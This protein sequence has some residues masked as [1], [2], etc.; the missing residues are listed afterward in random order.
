MGDEDEWSDISRE[1]ENTVD[2]FEREAINQ[3]GSGLWSQIA[4]KD[5]K[6]RTPIGSPRKRKRKTSESGKEANDNLAA[7][8][9]ASLSELNPGTQVAPDGRKLSSAVGSPRK[10]E[11]NASETGRQANGRLATFMLAN[12]LSDANKQRPDSTLSKKINHIVRRHKFFT[13]QSL[14]TYTTLLR[15]AFERDVYDFTRALKLTRSQ[16]KTA[17]VCARRLYGEESYDSDNSRRDDEEV[18]HPAAVLIEGPAL[19]GL[20]PPATP[21]V[22]SIQIEMT[23]QNGVL[24]KEAGRKRAN[25]WKDDHY[26]KK[27]RTN[28]DSNGDDSLKEGQDDTY[29]A[30]DTTQPPERR[31][32]S[33]APKEQPGMYTNTAHSMVHHR[34]PP[35]AEDSH[36]ALSSISE[37][38]AVNG[39]SNEDHQS[40]RF[41]QKAQNQ[42]KI[43]GEDGHYQGPT[44]NAPA[45][46]VDSDPPAASPNNT[47]K[48]AE[49]R[50]MP[51][52]TGQ[53]DVQEHSLTADQISQIIAG[54]KKRVDQL[55]EKLFTEGET[56]S[57]TG[58]EIDMVLKSFN[59][60]SLTAADL[61]HIRGGMKSVKMTRLA[62][63]A[64]LD[65]LSAVDPK[66]TVVDSCP[67]R[68]V[69]ANL[70][71][72]LSKTAED[73]N[74]NEGAEAGE[75]S[76]EYAVEELDQR[77]K[78]NEERKMVGEL[79]TKLLALKETNCVAA[80]I[81]E[82]YAKGTITVITFD[83]ILQALSGDRAETTTIFKLLK[84][85]QVD[86]AG[87]MDNIHSSN[88][89]WMAAR[90]RA[91]V[92]ESKAEETMECNGEAQKQN[93]DLVTERTGE[94]SWAERE[95]DQIE[96]E[97]CFD[98]EKLT[99]R[100]LRHYRKSTLTITKLKYIITDPDTDRADLAVVL[101]DMKQLLG[102]QRYLALKGNSPAIESNCVEAVARLNQ[103][104]NRRLSDAAKKALIEKENRD[105]AVDQLH[106]REKAKENQQKQHQVPVAGF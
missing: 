100:A 77:R 84:G 22:P 16:A 38:I 46:K 56:V 62:V 9:L 12:L 85:W 10:R 45:A 4:P 51:V 89:E 2:D 8:M 11:R 13:E 104:A 93:E 31:R 106:M 82:M 79:L 59:D 61:E 32:E 1:T 29:A 99:N 24:Q 55:L 30:E 39:L 87:V 19:V 91:E 28:D 47:Q 14:S 36:V 41:V 48:V 15:R 43:T 102:G 66:L 40:G 33:E 58:N 17:V 70:G 7:L 54:R 96:H 94:Q 26:D 5:Q 25:S 98:T 75:E 57:Q 20:P 6:L 23:S 92:E 73:K 78:R 86:I 63:I 76:Q 105:P 49:K 35:I 69:W 34:A 81:L 27:R 71:R 3:Q 101:K 97:Q 18:D 72:D 60:R 90:A 67:S 21:A 44:E 74:E 68:K 52:E 103:L 88:A 37:C 95:K 50:G 64:I 80:E 53:R 42:K 83:P 65:E